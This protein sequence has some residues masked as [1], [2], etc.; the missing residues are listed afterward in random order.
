MSSECDSPN[1]IEHA[2]HHQKLNQPANYL[3]NHLNFNSDVV[4]VV[5]QKYPSF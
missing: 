4:G 3:S 1:E 5:T 2:K